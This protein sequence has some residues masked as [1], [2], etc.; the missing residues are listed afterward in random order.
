MHTTPEPQPTI[1]EI[2]GSMAR[3]LLDDLHRTATGQG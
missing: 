3:D 1:E 2:V